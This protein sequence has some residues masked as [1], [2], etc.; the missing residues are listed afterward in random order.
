MEEKIFCRIFV[1]DLLADHESLTLREEHALESAINGAL[2]H[3]SMPYLIDVFAFEY[4]DA[5]TVL[6]D[7]VHAIIWETARQWCGEHKKDAR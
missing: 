7:D 4:V 3:A 1:G 5:V 2:Q 6:P